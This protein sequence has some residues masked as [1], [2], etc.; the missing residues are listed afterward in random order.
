H[1]TRFMKRRS[2]Q[3]SNAPPYLL[4]SEGFAEKLVSLDYCHIICP[5]LVNQANVGRHSRRRSGRGR[6]ARLSSQAGI[7]AVTPCRTRRDF[8]LVCD[9]TELRSKRLLPLQ[10][11]FECQVSY[12]GDEVQHGRSSKS[13]FSSHQSH[14]IN[15][16]ASR[17]PRPVARRCASYTSPSCSSSRD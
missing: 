8:L 11:G 4:S 15:T 12:L 7:L 3:P 16:S 2:A 9:R 14:P 10:F 6:V 17:S 1:T 13:S 5:G